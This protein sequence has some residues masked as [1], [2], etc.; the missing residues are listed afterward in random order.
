MTGEGRPQCFVAEEV[1]KSLNKVAFE[2]AM[3]KLF[4]YKHGYTQEFTDWVGEGWE[5]IQEVT[6]Q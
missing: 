3:Y 1:V 5:N 6:K 2:N 4:L